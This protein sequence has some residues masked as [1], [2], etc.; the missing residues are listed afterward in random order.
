MATIDDFMPE[1][2]PEV[3][4]CPEPSIIIAI[5]NSL[6]EFCEKSLYW[7]VN[8]DQINVVAGKH[9]YDLVSPESDSF[10]AGI[11]VASHEV[12]PLVPTTEDLLDLE[13]PSYINKYKNVLRYGLG[14]PWRATTSEKPAL[15]FSPTHREIRLVGI[16][17][18]DLAGGLTIKAGLKPSRDSEEVGDIVYED[19]SEQIA[20]GALYR[21]MMQ[22]NKKW[23]N[24]KSAIDYKALFDQSVSEAKGR[25]LAGFH[26]QDQGVIRSKTYY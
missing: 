7:A 5:R 2:S 14:D 9:T 12:V 16:P 8:L 18:A 17:T 22:P 4:G 6:I 1:V 3:N 19:Y 11:L 10:I 26:R 21:L 23:S 25:R 13:W 20:W 15:F 24:K